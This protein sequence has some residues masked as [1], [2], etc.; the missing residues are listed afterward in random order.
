MAAGEAVVPFPGT[1]SIYLLPCFIL[2]SISCD[3]FMGPLREPPACLSVWLG[4][5]SAGPTWARLGLDASIHET[6]R[7]VG[8]GDGPAGA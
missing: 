5:P 3:N 1:A 4:I 2:D 7:R 6:R 8:G